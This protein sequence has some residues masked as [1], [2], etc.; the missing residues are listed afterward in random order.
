[1]TDEEVAAVAVRLVTHGARVQPTD[2]DDMA[3]DARL[4]VWLAR[5]S[6][7]GTGDPDRFAL[8]RAKWAVI[9]GLRARRGRPDRPRSIDPA[10]MASTDAEVEEGVTIGDLLVSTAPEVERVVLAR[11]RA[12]RVADHLASLHPLK[13]ASVL[14]CDEG[15]SQAQVAARFGVTPSAVNQCRKKAMHD[16]RSVAA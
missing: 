4:A 1:M 13:A 16:V 9:D 10:Q 8:T 14:A 3:Q 5:Q 11:D 7:D 12:R 6:F 2:L 15:E